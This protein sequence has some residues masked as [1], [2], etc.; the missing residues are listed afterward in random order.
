MQADPI[1]TEVVAR[2]LTLAAEEM[3]ATLISLAFSPN[4][5]APPTKSS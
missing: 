3:G 2:S 4:R 1:L 5:A